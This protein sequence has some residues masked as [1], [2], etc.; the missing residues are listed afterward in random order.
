MRCIATFIQQFL[1]GKVKNYHFRISIKWHVKERKVLQE[2]G[3]P[4][5]YCVSYDYYFEHF[6]V[7]RTWK[8]NVSKKKAFKNKNKDK[9]K[10]Q[11][12][13]DPS[14]KTLSIIPHDCVTK[15]ARSEN[16]FESITIAVK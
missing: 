12:K 1:L 9:K 4:Q 5:S 7:A 3:S 2:F 15:Q 14:Q 16:R 10:K 8:N 11:K 6:L 13:N